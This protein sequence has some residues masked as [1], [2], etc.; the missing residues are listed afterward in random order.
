M[1]R[2]LFGASGIIFVRCGDFSRLPGPESRGGNIL[3]K[4]GKRNPFSDIYQDCGSGYSAPILPV[5]TKTPL[6]AA[7]SDDPLSPI[8]HRNDE[9]KDGMKPR[10]TRRGVPRGGRGRAERARFL[11]RRER[12]AKPGYEAAWLAGPGRG[13]RREYPERLRVGSSYEAFLRRR[14][15]G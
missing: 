10:K 5:A 12:R 4:S 9:D 7:S 3:S 14:A 13:R 2:C 8:W 6:P 11:D 15:G 1:P